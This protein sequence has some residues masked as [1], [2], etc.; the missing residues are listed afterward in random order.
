LA[1]WEP[2]IGLEIHAEL[3]TK[4]KVFCPCPVVWN[5]P[6]NTV[7]CPV[8][9]GFPGVLP[10]INEKAV[11]YTLKVALALNCH[12]HRQTLFERKN[13]YY[14]DLPK[15]YQISQKRLPLGY[16]AGDEQDE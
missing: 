7:T 12:I 9:L 16:D 1:E 4:S 5:A 6:P 3:A 10:V 14:P 8:C 15:G 2:V 13:Y 11:D